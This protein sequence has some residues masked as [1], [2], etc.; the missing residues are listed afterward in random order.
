MEIIITKQNVYQYAMALTARAATASEAFTQTTITEDNFP[1]LDVYLSEAV[2]LVE[3]EL[4]KKLSH[5]NAIDMILDESSIIIQIKE[6]KNADT[7]VYNLIE[8]GIRLF[9]AYYIAS[10]WLQ[11]SP[12]SSLA[13]VYGATAVTHLKTATDAI[14]QKLKTVIPESDYDT[15]DVEGSRMEQRPA[16]GS[17]YDTRGADGSRMVQKSFGS[18]YDTRI[19]DITDMSESMAHATLYGRRNRD[20]VMA[21]PGER[22]SVGEIIAVRGEGSGKQLEPAITR[23]GEHLISNQ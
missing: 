18:D 8:S 13:E 23:I 6:Q 20:N 11:T 1:L 12:A 9:T 19:T 17:D 21:R 3:G 22:I 15:R 2:P 4:R 5:S 16:N 10:R 7:S 14:I